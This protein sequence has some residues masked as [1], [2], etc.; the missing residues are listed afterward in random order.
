MKGDFSRLTFKPLKHYSGVLMQQGRV[1]LDADWNEQQAIFAHRQTIQNHD[2]IGASGAPDEEA[3]FAITIKDNDLMIG[4]GRYYVEGIL[5]EN[6]TPVKFSQQPDYPAATHQESVLKSDGHSLEMLYLDV[7]E[8]HIT[9]LDDPSIR[10]QAL[11][12]DCPDTTTRLKTV[13]QVKN[14]P[15]TP[16]STGLLK[17]LKNIEDVVSNY[18]HQN[19]ELSDI[20][21]L[22]STLGETIGKF[23]VNSAILPKIDQALA[24][25][26][27]IIKNF[28]L[29]Q[30]ISPEEKKQAAEKIIQKINDE[31]L[32]LL[33]GACWAFKSN[34]CKQNFAEWTQ[35]VDEPYRTL[36]VRTRPTQAIDSP[37]ELPQT[38]GY[39][40]LDNQLYRIEILQG[41]DP[42]KNEDKITFVW[43]RNNG[44]EITTIVNLNDNQDGN[45]TAIVDNLRPDFE[46]NLA[47][48]RIV[49]I[50]NSFRELNG[51]PGELAAV[52]SFNRS[53]HQLTL[54][55]KIEGIGNT[56]PVKMRCWDG[57]GSVK[58]SVSPGDWIEL[59]GGIQIQFAAG[60]YRPGDY[61]M[62]AARSD[63]E[64]ID[65]PNDA[66]GNPLEQM[67]AGIKHH[68]S[69]LALVWYGKENR[70]C[71]PLDPAVQADFLPLTTT[72]LIEEGFKTK[73]Q[74]AG[75]EIDS[76]DSLTSDGST[77][78]QIWKVRDCRNIFPALTVQ[79]P[80]LHVLRTSWH[81]DGYIDVK[82]FSEL[83]LYIILDGIPAQES[84]KNGLT[85]VI[86]LQIKGDL[87]ILNGDI[88]VVGNAI[89]WRLNTGDN[90]QVRNEFFYPLTN[91]VKFPYLV[92]VTLNGHG[93]WQAEQDTSCSSAENPQMQQQLSGANNG[94]PRH[95]RL[96]N[97]SYLDGQAFCKSGVRVNV[98]P[99]A[100]DGLPKDFFDT[101]MLN[102]QF[103]SGAGVQASNFES[104]F[105]VM[106][107][108]EG[109]AGPT[110]DSQPE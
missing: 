15:V 74:T 27:A 49:E 19:P 97:R 14:M 102:L 86:A 44:S 40:R 64:Q 99:N 93:I 101:T 11:G 24:Q 10:E 32:L 66:D 47:P 83:G 78:L 39:G 82:D 73:L 95:T 105:Y 80:A 21:E 110:D 36:N 79:P 33:R 46:V 63:S 96:G 91:D 18:V 2:I 5:C 59:E 57:V 30:D 75:D 104:W 42:S 45:T 76:A 107:A 100:V 28:K 41:G 88:D 67:P 70:D 55:R 7:W 98:P 92:H 90:D 37:C 69:R 72:L 25:I 65:W 81:N 23:P 68:Y 26:F 16:D 53:A 6:E 8:R 4:K 54:D 29:T 13:W 43:S 62:V 31:L 56:L 103:P 3:G 48:E 12:I 60:M 9:D 38:G 51:L 108:A 94:K 84:L 106:K 1:Q 35:L 109:P 52:F 89:R 85:V 87:K 50:T 61:W 17:V 34:L 58:L 20:K 22:Q 77:Y 71:M